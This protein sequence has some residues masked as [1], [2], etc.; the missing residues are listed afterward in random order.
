MAASVLLLLLLLCHGENTRAN[1]FFWGRYSVL[2]EG[3]IDP[4]HVHFLELPNIFPSHHPLSQCLRL[5][6]VPL[7]WAARS[8]KRPAEQTRRGRSPCQIHAVSCIRSSHSLQTYT[9]KKSL[10]TP[11]PLKFNFSICFPS[12]E[13]LFFVPFFGGACFIAVF[14]T[15]NINKN[16]IISNLRWDLLMSHLWDDI[17]ANKIIYAHA[18]THLKKK[19]K[20]CLWFLVSQQTLKISAYSVS[21]FSPW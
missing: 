10:C 15:M 12:C 21:L 1:I 20:T 16:V 14:C 4:A 11:P 17:P 2:P 8:G 13:S 18:D 9:K 3:F 5:P 19:K 7:P 6:Q